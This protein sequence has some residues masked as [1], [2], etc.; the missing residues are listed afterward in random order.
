MTRSSGRLRDRGCVSGF[1]LL[2]VLVTIVIVA[3]GLLGMAGLQSRTSVAEMESYQRVQA[4]VLAQ[5]M[6]DRIKSNKANAASYVGNDYGASANVDCTGKSG[7]DLDLCQWGN[8]V[9]GAGEVLGTSNVGTLLGGRGCITR[10]GGGNQYL[11]IIVW[12]GLIATQAPTVTCGQG[13]YGTDALRRA[14]VVPVVM[15]TLGIT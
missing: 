15:A 13:S 1:S 3:I 5:D 2:E 9:H 10:P 7:F 12:Q 8:A 11:V 6:A 14:V 4:L